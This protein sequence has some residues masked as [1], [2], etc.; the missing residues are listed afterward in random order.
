MFY[1]TDKVVKDRGL[2]VTQ[3]DI[4]PKRKQT[5]VDY[6]LDPQGALNPFNGGELQAAEAYSKAL[7]DKAQD[8]L[9]AEAAGKSSKS[10]A[11][12][13]TPAAKKAAPATKK[14]AAKKQAKE[15]K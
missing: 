10:E 2:Q 14:A 6:L 7:M 1:I 9:I 8:I 3:D 5:I 12:T 4:K 15:S 13:D 11:K